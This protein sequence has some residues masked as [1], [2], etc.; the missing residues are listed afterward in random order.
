MMIP[1][2]KLAKLMAKLNTEAGRM[3]MSFFVMNTKSV[4]NAIAYDSTN[5]AQIS[6]RQVTTAVGSTATNGAKKIQRREIQQCDDRK[7]I[8]GNKPNRGPAEQECEIDPGR[9]D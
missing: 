3:P 2:T 5:P 1:R 4:S 7:A 6:L 8:P 9:C